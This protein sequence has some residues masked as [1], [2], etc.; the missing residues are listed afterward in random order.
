[1]K[2]RLKITLVVTLC[3]AILGIFEFTALAQEVPKI[4]KEE[5]MGMLGNSNVVIID[6]RLGAGW[7]GSELKIKGAVREDPGNVS[8]WIG[9]YPKDKTLVF[10]CA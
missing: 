8:S 1:M 7:D 4:T 2:M 9:E 3:F 10:Y 6:V 5:I